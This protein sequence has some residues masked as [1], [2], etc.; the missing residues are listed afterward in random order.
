MPRVC[1]WKGRRA[2]LYVLC[3]ACVGA[4]G[5]LKATQSNPRPTHASTPQALGPRATVS[6]HVCAAVR[7]V[8]KPQRSAHSL[9]VQVVHR[10]QELR[11][12]QA[13]L[14]LVKELAALL[15]DGGGEVTFLAVRVHDVDSSVPMRA[16]VLLIGHH[17]WMTQ[18]AYL[19]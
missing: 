19:Q 10:K 4:A 1:V 5:G 14:L 11:Q 9:A 18:G 6:R 16:P 12:P 7:A 8:I 3:Y 17:E 13:Q 2:T 15:V